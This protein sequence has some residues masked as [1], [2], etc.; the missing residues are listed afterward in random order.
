MFERYTPEARRLI[1]FAHAESK[2]AYRNIETEH[3]LLG[4][5]R[6]NP[7]LVSRFIAS[8]DADWFRQHATPQAV[9]SETAATHIEGLAFSIESNRVLVFA[10]EEADRLGHGQVGIEHLLLGLLREEGCA[11]AKLLRARGA[12][13]DRIREEL[14]VSP[15]R[16][17]SSE[18]RRQQ[19]IA[20]IWTKWI[21]VRGCSLPQPATGDNESSRVG[22]YTISAARLMFFARYHAGR[23]GSPMVEPEHLLLAALREE[24]EHLNVFLPSAESRAVVGRQLEELRRNKHTAAGDF[25]YY[26]TLPLSAQVIQVETYAAEEATL[27]RSQHIRP[28][29]LLLGILREE[30][31]AAARILRE[32]GAQIERIRGELGEGGTA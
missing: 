19:E 2:L 30:A 32:H 31:S 26:E 12:D 17:L 8:T 13:P 28:E 20:E 27:L 3:L 23:L 18:Q 9:P 14:L 10:A 11:A 6:E 15:H 21:A 5:M 16:P 1:A 4:T 29:H 24:W 25:S 22:N 7:A